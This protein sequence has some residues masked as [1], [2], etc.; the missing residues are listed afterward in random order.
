MRVTDS[1]TATARGSPVPLPDLTRAVASP[2]WLI[3]VG[4]NAG[5]ISAVG[6]AELPPDTVDWL[7]IR[8]RS[9]PFAPAFAMPYIGLCGL[10]PVSFCD[11][12][13]ITAPLVPA[14]VTAV[15]ALLRMPL[16]MAPSECHSNPSA[17]LMRPLEVGT[18]LPGNPSFAYPADDRKLR[19]P[20]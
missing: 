7:P 13:Q 2:G 14:V 19:W 18:M 1:T 16:R 20:P 5:S 15:V 12:A 11:R 9:L 17:L 3:F 4:C 6:A 8:D 10:L